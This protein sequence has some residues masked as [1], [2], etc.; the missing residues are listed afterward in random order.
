MKLKTNGFTSV[1]MA[2]NKISIITDPSATKDATG[3]FSKVQA[4][5]VLYTTKSLI[6]TENTLEA[7]GL[8]N[9]VEAAE[10]RKVIEIVNPG[11]YEAG[12]V[13]IRRFNGENIYVLD[14]DDI[15]VVY[16]GEDSKAT[17]LD[18]FKDLGDVD[19]LIIPG[20]DSERY[21]GYEKLEKVIKAVDPTVLVP[22]GFAGD[23]VKLEGLKTSEEFI[24][25][26]GYTNVTEEKT[27]K[28]SKGKET[29]NKIMQ[30]VL[31]QA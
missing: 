20:G 16:V 28:M 10:D 21:M 17:S 4:D 7:E 29:D 13:F 15:R 11:E 2:F 31:L 9:K 19:I 12:E 26:F 14:E 18:I 27:F 22:T 25:H 30:V 8:T 24:K 1:K 6:G 23:G 5:V 3:S